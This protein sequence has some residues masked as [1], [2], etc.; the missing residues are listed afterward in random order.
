MR[1]KTGGIVLASLFFGLVHAPGLYL[2]TSRTG[3]ALGSSPS[4]LLAVGYAIVAISPTGFFLGTLWSRTRNLAIVV[5]I[6]GM[7]DLPSNVVEFVR[8]FMA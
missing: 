2:R 4:L 8:H 1:S 5:I 3:E 7:G 6:H